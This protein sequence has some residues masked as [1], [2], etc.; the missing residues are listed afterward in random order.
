MSER[1]FLKNL[2]KNY[3]YDIDKVDFIY[4]EVSKW[5]LTTQMKRYFTYKWV[6]YVREKE[7]I[8]IV[9]NVNELLWIVFDYEECGYRREHEPS[10][11]QI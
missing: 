4:N 8:T 6:R 7:D 10:F 11:L 1:I 5:S 2:S 3:Q 9:K